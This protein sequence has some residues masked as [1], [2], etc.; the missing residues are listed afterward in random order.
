MTFRQITYLQFANTGSIPGQALTANST[1][2][3]SWGAGGFSNGASIQVT[4]L[5]VNTYLS[6]N[7]SNGASGQFL[8]SNATGTFWSNTFYSSIGFNSTASFAST[9]NLLGNTTISANLTV[10]N[11]TLL[12]T[13]SAFGSTIVVTNT[14]PSGNNSTGAVVI[15]GGLG[16]NGNIYTAGRFGFANSSNA[17]A[18]Y[19]FYNPTI[20]SIDTAF[21]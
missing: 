11:A 8:T 16:V 20:G 4:N 18:M 2:G 10:T 7:N 13:N 5:T 17:S 21:G 12:L 3:V 1:G 19:T 15:A 9:V 6:A 14:T